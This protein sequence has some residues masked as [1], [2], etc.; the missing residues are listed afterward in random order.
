MAAINRK[1]G[2]RNRIEAIRVAATRGWI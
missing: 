2:A 1:V